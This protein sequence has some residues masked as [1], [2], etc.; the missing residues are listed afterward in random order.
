M[1]L[2]EGKMKIPVERL[3]TDHVMWDASTSKFREIEEIQPSLTYFL[4]RF[5]HPLRYSVVEK[6]KNVLIKSTNF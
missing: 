2:H 3:T 5:K 4:I 1:P 6:G